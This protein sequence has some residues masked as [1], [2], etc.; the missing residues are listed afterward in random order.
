M[1]FYKGE[2]VKRFLDVPNHPIIP[3]SELCRNAVIVLSTRSFNMDQVKFRSFSLFAVVL[4]WTLYL[5]H[6]LLY[7]PLK[8]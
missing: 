1:E 5:N 4:T 8:A 2:L 6:L 7:K 3:L